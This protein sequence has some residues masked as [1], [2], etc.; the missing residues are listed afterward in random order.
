MTKRGVFIYEDIEVYAE[1]K[2]SGKIENLRFWKIK[3][4]IYY[5]FFWK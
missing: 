2:K 4:K 5:I 1:R 3:E